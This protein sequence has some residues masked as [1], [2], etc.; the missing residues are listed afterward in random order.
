M[1]ATEILLLI[2]AAYAGLT[3]LLTFGLAAYVMWGRLRGYERAHPVALPDAWSTA[4]RPPAGFSPSRIGDR[5]AD[6]QGLGR[7]RVPIA[8]ARRRSRPRRGHSD[9]RA[10]RSSRRP[11]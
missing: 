1:Q 3:L 10:T 11:E 7:S 4:R 6:V 5:A 2:L 8:L 9:F